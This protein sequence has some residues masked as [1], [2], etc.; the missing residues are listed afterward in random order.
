MSLSSIQEARQSEKAAK[1]ADNHTSLLELAPTALL[2][3]KAKMFD[4]KKLS[5]LEL[6]A[7]ACKYFDTKLQLSL[8]K[9]ALVTVFDSKVAASKHLIESAVKNISTSAEAD[10]DEDSDALRHE[11]SD[12][13]C[14]GDSDALCDGDSDASCD[15][16]NDAASD[17]DSDVASD[18]DCL[19]ASDEN[20][21]ENDNSSNISEYEDRFT[22]KRSMLS[23]SGRRLT[24]K[25]RFEI[26]G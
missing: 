10:A 12:A 11:D 23:F 9:G 4:S 1:A 22:K 17:E 2:K 8:S 24:K 13:S 3:Y 26:E 18:E 25:K 6:C 21:E 5:K 7:I 15:E 20:S 14:D 16:D 19:V